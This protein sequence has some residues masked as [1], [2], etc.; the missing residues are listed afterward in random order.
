MKVSSIQTPKIDL[1]ESI[2]LTEARSYKLWESAGRAL[3]E[4][5][6]TP[7]QIQQLFQQIEQ[8]ATDAG[9]NRTLL[10]KGK[11]AAAAVNKAW[12]DLKTKVQ[13]SA[14]IANVDSAYDSAVA[15]IEAGLGG[16][17]NAVN[18]VVQKYREFAKAHPIAQ[19]LIYS[20]LIAAAGISGA[21]LGG[22]AVLGLLK[23]TDKLLQGEKFSSAAYSGAKTG[24]MAYGAS[25]IGDYI[26]G[27]PEGDTTSFK[28]GQPG[29]DEAGN[30]LPFKGGQPG[31][32]EV[33]NPLPAAPRPEVDAETMAK[34]AADAKAYGIDGA[35]STA[36]MNKAMLKTADT[37]STADYSQVSPTTASAPTTAPTATASSSVNTPDA[38]VANASA[39]A[40]PDVPKSLPPRPTN[41]RLDLPPETPDQLAKSDSFVQD[42]Y[43]SADQRNSLT[44]ASDTTT[45]NLSQ[46]PTSVTPPIGAGSNP[47]YLQQVASG[48]HP[49]PMMSADDAK[50]ALDWQAQNG[51]QYIKPSA[52]NFIA[53]TDAEKAQ[54][55]QNWANRNP[56][57]RGLNQSHEPTGTMIREYVDRDMTVF[58]WALNERIGKPRGGVR[59][60][61]AGIK[62]T[63]G[64]AASW[65]GDK[66][67][68]AGNWVATKG[69][70]LTT[71]VTA[72]KLQQA[73]SK[74]GLPPDSDAMAQFLK[75]QGIPDETITGVYGT[76]GIPAPT[77]A[78]A[79]D[80]TT[81]ATTAVNLATS[82]TLPTPPATNT[83]TPAP[84]GVAGA[85]D[86]AIGKGGSNTGVTRTNAPAATTTEPV[87]DAGRSVFSNPDQL[88]ASFKKYSNEH[89]I[90]PAWRGVLKDI[91]LTALRRVESKQQKMSSIIKEARRIEQQI[92]SI[93]KAK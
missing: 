83:A 81:P 7:D 36:D 82:T 24:A 89:G 54:A 4:A 49:R 33:G 19:G 8:G 77:T 48:Q 16:P 5:E 51:G 15:K 75:D 3:K 72:D 11:D 37:S 62:D 91:L 65:A 27:K 55:A 2:T 57:A 46:A 32:D 1:L 40:T 79:A 42:M 39:A 9:S 44:P 90:A 87:S 34:N 50:A 38:N 74:A 30:P 17:D 13:N 69:H 64:K 22:A 47:D 43:K 86:R 63:I 23:M 41:P 35:D 73:W 56:Y 18:Q 6:L 10:G 60:T 66:A 26:K 80:T 84:D 20:A 52:S 70:N 59:L 67:K 45:S 85:F 25:K 92:K 14:P 88:L 93:K 58:M 71:N 53:P 78:P 61:E 12:E 21:G 76:M 31:Y 28:G 29:Y 68:S